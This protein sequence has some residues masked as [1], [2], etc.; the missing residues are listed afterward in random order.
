MSKCVVYNPASLDSVLA[1]A[2]IITHFQQDAVTIAGGMLASSDMFEEYYWVGVKPS[3]ETFKTYSPAKHRGIFID[4]N[5]G[6]EGY[7]ARF[8]KTMEDEFHQIATWNDMLPYLK[9]MWDGLEDMLQ[10]SLTAI[11]AILYTN[12]Q[13]LKSYW[14]LVNLLDEFKHNSH[15][16]LHDQSLLYRNVNAAMEIIS[17]CKRPKTPFSPRKFDNFQ[18]VMCVEKTNGETSYLGEYIDFLR[19]IKSEIND[20]VEWFTTKIDGKEKTMPVLNMAP[21]RA[22]W[23]IRILSAVYKFGV[24]YDHRN[25]KSIYTPYSY[26]AGHTESLVNQITKR[27]DGRFGR[28]AVFCS[29]V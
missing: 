7:M 15:M 19:D 4:T 21:E 3:K 17:T 14:P 28:G 25:G 22:P 24:I 8:E 2:V 29:L 23:A 26:I 27:H 6:R 1:T 18:P 9:P 10:P 20:C 11:A 5:D 13:T 12:E 16:S